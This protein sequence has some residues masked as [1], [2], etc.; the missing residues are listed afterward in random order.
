MKAL[1]FSVFTLFLFHVTSGQEFIFTDMNLDITSVSSCFSC[2]GG[3]ELSM[4]DA[5]E[6][7]YRWNDDSGA[8]LLIE[9]NTTGLSSIQNLCLGSDPS[10]C[11][12]RFGR[13]GGS[14]F[15]SCRRSMSI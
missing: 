11:L 8:I 12:I 3:C 5:Q 15:L 1:I 10:D 6:Y 9:T 14:F 4:P 7:T 2:D 13:A